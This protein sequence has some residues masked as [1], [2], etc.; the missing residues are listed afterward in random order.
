M[1][2][3]RAPASGDLITIVR[4]LMQ[5][6]EAALVPGGPRQR[7]LPVGAVPVAVLGYWLLLIFGAKDQRLLTDADRAFSAVTLRPQRRK[8]NRLQMN[9]SSSCL[10]PDNHAAEHASTVRRAR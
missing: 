1:Y 8:P 9:A 10:N 6:S 2:A 3:A 7:A 5:A 4:L